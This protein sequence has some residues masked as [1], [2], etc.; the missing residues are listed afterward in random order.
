[1][2]CIIDTIGSKLP[3]EVSSLMQNLSEL[4][5]IGLCDASADTRICMLPG[6]CPA[7]SARQLPANFSIP[8]EFRGDLLLA[9]D[10]Y[11][12]MLEP[13]ATGEKSP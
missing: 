11:L 5:R 13:L 12:V 7:I 9:T 8:R 2:A 4:S 1:V 10:N 3:E 6:K